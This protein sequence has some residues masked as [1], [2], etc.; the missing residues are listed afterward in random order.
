MEEQQGQVIEKYV[1]NITLYHSLYSRERAD[2]IDQG[3]AEDSTIT[4]L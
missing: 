1:M 4:Y 2:V 3:M